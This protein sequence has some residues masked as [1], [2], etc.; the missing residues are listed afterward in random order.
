MIVQ[1]YWSWS[2]SFSYV[3]LRDHFRNQTICS[4]FIAVC[5]GRIISYSFKAS[6]RV[7]TLQ[8]T[9]ERSW[10]IQPWD[11]SYTI[12]SI[13]TFQNLPSR[14][15]REE[16]LPRQTFQR[17]IFSELLVLGH[18]A[19]SEEWN[20]VHKDIP[21]VKDEGTVSLGHWDKSNFKKKAILAS[22][23]PVL[24]DAGGSAFLFWIRPR[25]AQVEERS[26]R[27]LER[28]PRGKNSKAQW[29]A[30]DIAHG[31]HSMCGMTVE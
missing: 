12:I 7:N 30:R 22:C 18:L 5:G 19:E 2:V 14:E 3:S 28:R 17:G 21:E 25:S 11:K 23:P 27:D 24:P 8:N 31:R 9:E 20:E 16:K 1:H 4:W 29:L 13:T 10:T 15:I 26:Y 6:L